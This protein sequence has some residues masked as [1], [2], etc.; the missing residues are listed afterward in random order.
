MSNQEINAHKGTEL[1]DLKIAAKR[2]NQLTP[3]LEKI[4]NAGGDPDEHKNKSIAE[5]KNIWKG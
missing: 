4:K 5:L 1:P 3:L 2:Q